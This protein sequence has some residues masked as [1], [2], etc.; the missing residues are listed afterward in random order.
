MLPTMSR[1]A[2]TWQRV[3]AALASDDYQGAYELLARAWAMNAA[4][5]AEVYLYAASVH[6]LFGDAGIPD[7]ALALAQARELYPTVTETALY[8][9]LHLES[10]ARTGEAPDVPAELGSHPDPLVRF[11][12]LS[13][14]ALSEHPQAVLALELRPN[15]LPE[16]LRWRLRS[17]QAD[18]AEHLAD[19]AQAERLYGEAAELTTGLNRAAMRQEQAALN[20]QLG[21][22]DK[23]KRLLEEARQMYGQFPPPEEGLNL[24]TWHYLWAQTQLQLGQPEQALEAIREADR[25]ERAYGDSSYGVALVWG[26]VLTHLGQQELALETFERALSLATPAD[27]PFAYHELG[28]VLLDLDRPLEA[29]ERLEA[30]LRQPDYPYQPEVLADLAECDYRTGRLREAQ[31]LAEQALSGGAVVP[32]SLVLG[33]LA[34]EYYHLEEAA[35]HY[36]RVT[37]TAP[38]GSRDW[39]AAH[40]LAADVLAQQGYQQPAQVLMHAQQALEWTP[41]NDEWHAPLQEYLR[42][43]QA[44]LEDQPRMLN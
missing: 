19:L 40:Q 33:H 43:A 4:E 23:T 9:A 41:E 10:S 1:A 16:H 18:S 35:E 20:L 7:M 30:A 12:T 36:E 31:A 6:S 13:A 26:Q 2:T 11:H 14:L 37:M 27:R 34:L 8:Q 22:P 21:T 5:R 38:H 15:E 44:V 32:A 42:R 29:R 28:V 25:L 24:A 17:W 39:I 3:C